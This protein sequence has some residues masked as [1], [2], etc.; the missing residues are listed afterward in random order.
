MKK[1]SNPFLLKG[2]LSKDLF[3]DRQKEVD[4]LFANVTN[5][6]DTTLISARKMGKTGLIMRFF[7]HL[8]EQGD[9]KYLYVDIFSSRNLSE[10]IKLL[11]E[12]IL[13]TFPEPTPIGKQF[14]DFIKGFRP[15]IGYDSLTGQPQ[16]QISYQSAQEKEYTLLGLLRFLENQGDKIVVA[17]DEFQQISDYPEKNIEAL[18]R[19][20]TQNLSNIHFIFCGS[21]KAMMIDL[22]S[23]VKRPFYASTQYL[24]LE[25]ID[26]EVYSKFILD[27][28]AESGIGMTEDSLAMVLDWSLLHTFYTQSLCNML[29]YMADDQ[30]TIDTVKRACVELLK[31]NE[32]VFYQYRQLL[33]SAQWNFLIAIAK[34]GEVKQ[35]TAQKFIAKYEI[36]TPANARRISRALVEKELLLEITNKKVTT[37][38]VYDVFLS[39]W[40]ENEY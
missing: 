33:T 4:Q 6:I 2:Y 10:F 24:S 26:S 5:G 32:P 20:Y 29:Y 40:L 11:A 23:N 38:R 18:L 39:R 15:M 37:Y 7:D 28:F 8:K 36:G 21:R 34:E 19:T 13:L 35:L 3:C 12:A 9:I 25:K 17:I 30:V 14:M 27:H 22:F 16:I 31:R 1:K